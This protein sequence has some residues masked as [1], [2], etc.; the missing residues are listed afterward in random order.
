MYDWQ[1]PELS[2][3]NAKL[4]RQIDTVR[5]GKSYWSL[6]KFLMWQILVNKRILIAKGSTPITNIEQG[7]K[8]KKQARTGTTYTLCTSTSQA[9]TATYV[10]QRSPQSTDCLSVYTQNGGR[11]RKGRSGTGEAKVD[12]V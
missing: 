8:A 6:T 5:G 3:G 12:S 11:S 7:I 2:S 4:V 10:R 1:L 9:A